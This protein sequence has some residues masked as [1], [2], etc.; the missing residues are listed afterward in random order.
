MHVLDWVPCWLTP[1]WWAYMLRRP[2][3]PNWGASWLERFACRWQDAQ[4][5]L[6]A[7]EY[8]LLHQDYYAHSA[9]CGC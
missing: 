8:R 1:S 5:Q 9:R 2:D 3:S 4:A 6:L 7:G